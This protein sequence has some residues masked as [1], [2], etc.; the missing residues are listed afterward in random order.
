MY[1]TLLT[2]MNPE[3]VEMLGIAG[4]DLIIMHGEHGPWDPP[5]GGNWGGL[6]NAPV[7]Q[8]PSTQATPAVPDAPLAL[9][10][11]LPGLREILSTSSLEAQR[12]LLQTLQLLNGG[13]GS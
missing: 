4:L 10:R 6:Q 2:V 9:F 8:L 5:P 1:G 11:G 13:R 12:D 7:C 3:L